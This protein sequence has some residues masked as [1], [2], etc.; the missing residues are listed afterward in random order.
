M[1]PKRRH[2]EPKP[3]QVSN[4]SRNVRF[5]NVCSYAYRYLQSAHCSVRNISNVT[6]SVSS[7][8]EIKLFI[9]ICVETLKGSPLFGEIFER[10]TSANIIQKNLSCILPNKTRENKSIHWNIA[11]IIFF[12]SYEANENARNSYRHC[13]YNSGRSLWLI[14]Y[15]S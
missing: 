6:A 9:K 8:T 4:C 12:A 14:H 2:I 11:I 10:N 5:T 3:T 15:H 7:S 1:F 13:A